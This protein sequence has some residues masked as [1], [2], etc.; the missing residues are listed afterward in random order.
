LIIA[1]S[2]DGR[3]DLTNRPDKLNPLSSHTLH[4]I[5]LAARWSTAP[6]SEGGRGRW[7]DARSPPA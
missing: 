2:P 3:G 7:P 6:R 1:V 4:E 5:E